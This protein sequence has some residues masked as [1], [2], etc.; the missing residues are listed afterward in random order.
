VDSFTANVKR[1][2]KRIPRGRVATYGQIA[3]IA[4]TTRGARQ[5]VW[6]L[7]S[8]AEKEKLPWFRVVNGKGRIALQP[9]DGYELQKALLERE[10]IHFNIGDMIDLER[11][12]WRPDST[13][14]KASRRLSTTL[15]KRTSRTTPK[16]TL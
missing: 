15:R 2:L 12:Q 5:V 10:G 8:S 3:L 11:Y 13:G 14:K 4:G 6:V 9:G 7:H 1:A 16:K